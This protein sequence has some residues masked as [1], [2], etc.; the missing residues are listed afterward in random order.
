MRIEKTGRFDKW[1]RKLKDREA[2]A[3]IAN[4]LVRIAAGNLGDHKSVGDSVS[5][6]RIDYGPGY[7]LYYTILDDGSVLLLLAGGTKRRQQ[8]DIAM[9]KA[10][11]EQVKRN[12]T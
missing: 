3:R 10:V 11:L 1:L 8:A 2:K 4:R 6:I 12:T 5:E 7:R 9:A